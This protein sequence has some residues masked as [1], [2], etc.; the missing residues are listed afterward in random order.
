[1]SRK[2]KSALD[3]ARASKISRFQDAEA[4]NPDEFTDTERQEYEAFKKALRRSKQAQYN[5]KSYTKMKS[6]NRVQR[7]PPVA[8]MSADRVERQ[9]EVRRRSSARVKFRKA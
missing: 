1:M 4:I 6:E 5:R 8:Q 3:F 9:R 2:C 7:Q